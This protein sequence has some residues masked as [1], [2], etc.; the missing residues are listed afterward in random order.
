MVCVVFY[1]HKHFFCFL[2]PYSIHLIDTYVTLPLDVRITLLICLDSFTICIFI[3]L[4]EQIDLQ[5]KLLNY[6]LGSNK[7]NIN[8][9]CVCISKHV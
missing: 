1:I 3:P 9:T 5:A 7:S 4:I 8:Q 6:F 2:F